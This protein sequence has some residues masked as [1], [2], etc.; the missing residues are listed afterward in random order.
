MFFVWQQDFLIVFHPILLFCLCDPRITAQFY[1][2]DQ[3]LRVP[4][5]GYSLRYCFCRPIILLRF[6][7]TFSDFQ[8]DIQDDRTLNE[9]LNHCTALERAIRRMPKKQVD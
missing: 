7:I 2:Q 6:S 8:L 5:I 9:N 1:L 3:Y 4:D